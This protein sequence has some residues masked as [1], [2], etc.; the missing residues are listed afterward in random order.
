[1]WELSAKCKNSII[2]YHNSQQGDCEHQPD[3]TNTNVVEEQCDI[4]IKSK[5]QG[6]KVTPVLSKKN[7]CFFFAGHLILCLT[8]SSNKSVESS[9]KKLSK[10]VQISESIKPSLLGL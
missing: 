1:M 6:S 5:L 9:F 4:L 10:E 7:L 3:L 2:S 8:L